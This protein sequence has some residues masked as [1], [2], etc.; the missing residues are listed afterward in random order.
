MSGG[1]QG[2]PLSPAG[3]FRHLFHF[4][5]STEPN[6]PTQP[7][8]GWLNTQHGRHCLHS[9]SPVQG[10]CGPR[11]ADK[12]WRIGVPASPIPGCVAPGLR[13]HLSVS[14][15]KQG[16][17]PHLPWGAA[18]QVFIRPTWQVGT[19]YSVPRSIFPLRSQGEYCS[20]NYSPPNQVIYSSGSQ[21][22][23]AGGDLAPRR[24]LA[25]SCR[26]FLVVMT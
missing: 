6:T 21:L 4:I 15:M 3:Y 2:E 20:Y 18:E 16:A 12:H 7:A 1:Q 10:V 5:I 9:E 23:W 8:A 25:M 14:A 17:I 11:E 26:H 24:H 19:Q 13:L 22:G